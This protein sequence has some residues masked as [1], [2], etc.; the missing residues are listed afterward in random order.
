[1]MRVTVK[2]EELRRI[3]T[4]KAAADAHIAE[5][6][7]EV[8]WLRKDLQ[9]AMARPGVGLVPSEGRALEELRG[10]LADRTLEVAA[11]KDEARWVPGRGLG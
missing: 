7:S 2:E 10:Q 1:M 8:T 3:A 4:S 9:A 5:L 11:A 6:T